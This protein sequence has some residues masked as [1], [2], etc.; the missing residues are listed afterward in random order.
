MCMTPFLLSVW[1]AGLDELVELD[2]GSSAS[3][4]PGVKI[5]AC[6]RIAASSIAGILIFLFFVISCFS[7]AILDTRAIPR[8][9]PCRFMV[10]VSE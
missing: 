8:V 1:L 7:F 9:I 3:E 2:A 6:T 10:N 5:I 4:H